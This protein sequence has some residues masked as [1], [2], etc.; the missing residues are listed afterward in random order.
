[1]AN[2][3]ELSLGLRRSTRV[4]MRTLVRLQI[5]HQDG[6]IESIEGYSMVVN[7]HG[8]RIE[9]G[10]PAFEGDTVRQVKVLATGAFGSGKVVWVS[11]GP[12]EKGKHEFAVEMD[13]DRNIWGVFFPP[14]DW[15]L[16]SPRRGAVSPTLELTQEPDSLSS[17]PVIASSTS[18]AVEAGVPVASIN[19]PCAVVAE[20]QSGIEIEDY[21][22]DT[23]EAPPTPLQRPPLPLEILLESTEMVSSGNGHSD[24]VTFGG[25][26]PS[27][28]PSTPTISSPTTA[29]TENHIE[30]IDP[31]VPRSVGGTFSEITEIPPP[32]IPAAGNATSRL[33]EVFNDMVGSVLQTRINGLSEWVE[34]ETR[35][36]LVRAQEQAL[37]EY[38]QRIEDCTNDRRKTLEDQVIEI[39]DQ[40]QQAIEKNMQQSLQSTDQ[41]VQQ[42]HQERL[43][44]LRDQAE[45]QAQEIL[46]AK[47]DVFLS[48]LN[49]MVSET[50][51]G[52]HKRHEETLPSLQTQFIEQCQTSGSN[53]LAEH[54]DHL[55][56]NYSQFMKEAAGKLEE[57]T[58]LT[59]TVL[60]ASI[61]E[62]QT[63]S[64]Q[65]VGEANQNLQHQMT[66]TANDFYSK[67]LAS[68]SGK[69]GQ[70]E[71]EFLRKAQSEMEL[72]IQK[73][74]RRFQ[75]TLG[76]SMMQM[77]RALQQE[78]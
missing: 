19:E 47:A 51:A 54:L 39:V 26:E 17:D 40:G 25:P 65:L 60:A 4:A 55:Q 50:L 6:S 57:I 5:Q 27:D 63:R 21:C 28:E 11:N 61:E 42:V 35:S 8:A 31:V 9:S 20:P 29:V 48:Q 44:A 15:G 32:S 53:L 37:T 10:K 45:V 56:Q 3:K 49:A 14:N 46:S 22:L 64:N 36:H 23:V 12:N 73:N 34:A 62:L 24:S 16:K 77:G 30:S 59:Q 78:R 33:M 67:I 70:K 13:D 7:K 76:E 74:L 71:E 69:L 66:Q 38:Q 68:L 41:K 52:F 1:M 58:N 2:E 18:S 72:A 75:E 43:E